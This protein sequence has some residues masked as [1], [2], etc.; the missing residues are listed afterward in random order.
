MATPM[1]VLPMV[2]YMVLKMVI[3]VADFVLHT[4]NS[5]GPM[6]ITQ[7]PVQ[8]WLHILAK[9]PLQIQLWLKLLNPS[10]MS[11]MN[12]LTSMLIQVQQPT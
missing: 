12:H 3:E 6:V 2:V 11:L 4:V 10:V 9:V 5:A 8:N 7:S 1:L